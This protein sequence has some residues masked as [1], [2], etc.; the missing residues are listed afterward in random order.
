MVFSLNCL[1]LGEASIRS[2]S[3]DISDEIIVGPNKIKYKDIKVSHVKSLILSDSPDNLNLWK[4]DRVS[5]D[6][7]DKLLQTFSTEDDIKE[8]LGGVLMIP[9]FPLSKY[10]D[11]NS[12]KDEESKFSIHIFVTFTTGKCLPTF[13]LSNKK[14]A[15]TKYRVC[16]DHFFS[17]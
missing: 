8:K 4:V 2:I 7:N 15:V 3:V 11:E 12:F 6:K 17:R 13:Y 10:F 5:V 14:F 16:S 9:R 1:F